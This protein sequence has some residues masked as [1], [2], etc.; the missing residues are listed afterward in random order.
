MPKESSKRRRRWRTTPSMARVS[1]VAGDVDFLQHRDSSWIQNESGETKDD[2]SFHMV[3]HISEEEPE[4]KIV[5]KKPTKAKK[6]RKARPK[7]K[8]PPSIDESAMR[9]LNAIFE[10]VEDYSLI[11]EKVYEDPS[12]SQQN[13]DASSDSSSWS[14]DEKPRPLNASLSAK[15]SAKSPSPKN[16]L[17]TTAVNHSA[18]PSTSH[19]WF[20]SQPEIQLDQI[21][22]ENEVTALQK[23]FSPVKSVAEISKVSLRLSLSP[24]ALENHESAA[25]STPES[26]GEG[27]G[28]KLS[29]PPI[30]VSESSRDEA[31]CKNENKSAIRLSLSFRQQEFVAS[32]PVR[33]AGD[34]REY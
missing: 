18:V 19:S 14:L 26:S 12:T 32:T 2:P 21:Q 9:K 34:G 31:A 3:E 13:N 10:E 4:P 33:N 8:K 24:A 25:F 28:S 5:L 17:L 6:A 16:I 11:I 30:K 23:T 15:N 27:R 1:I 22:L 20:E 29:D 7:P